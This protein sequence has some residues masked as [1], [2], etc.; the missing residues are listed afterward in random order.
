[1]KTLFLILAFVLLMLSVVHTG[2]IPAD[3]TGFSPGSPQILTNRVDAGI[4]APKV[5]D[6]K[7]STIPDSQLPIL[8]M[9]ILL[10]SGLLGL[11]LLGIRR[12]KI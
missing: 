11:A 7:Q 10:G 1:M 4:S 5:A 2:N 8:S 9:A 3:L 6:G 12:K